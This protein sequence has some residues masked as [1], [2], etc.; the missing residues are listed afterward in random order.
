MFRQRLN[1]WFVRIVLVFNAGLAIVL[2]TPLSEAMY[3]P[4]IVDE[5]PPTQ[6]E[7]IIIFSAGMFRDGT[8]NHNTLMR[9]RRGVELYRQ[10]IAPKII[11]LGGGWQT[12]NSLTLAEIMQKEL[13]ERLCVPNEAIIAHDETSHT[14]DD[15]TSL[16]HRFE[17]QIDFNRAV[18]VSSSYHTYRIKRILVEKNISGAVI[19]V[20]PYELSPRQSVERLAFFK[21]ICREYAAI[22]YSLVA[23]WL[24]LY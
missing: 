9:L 19:A 11:T 13:A 8:P 17:K 16:M 10:G 5:P 6:A 15:I 21:E 4:L 24:T 20:A 7:A 12:S 1:R 18:F 22:L 23:G 3:R 14:Y 2:F